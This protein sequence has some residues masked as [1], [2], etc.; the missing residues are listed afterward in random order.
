[1]SVAEDVEHPLFPRCPAPSEKTRASARRSWRDQPRGEIGGAAGG[2]ARGGDFAPADVPIGLLSQPVAETD[3]GAMR[4]RAPTARRPAFDEA[5]RGKA[6]ASVDAARM[7]GFEEGPRGGTGRR[8]CARPEKGRGPEHV[9]HARS[10]AVS[11]PAG[12]F[13]VLGL[14]VSEGSTNR[15][16][17]TDVFAGNA[18]E[19]KFGRASAHHQEVTS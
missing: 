4:H 1:M 9:L 3:R 18:G 5:P 13:L 6:A 15:L 8:W 7:T 14:Q 12:H 2:V 16:Q 17:V 19:R 10:G 11:G